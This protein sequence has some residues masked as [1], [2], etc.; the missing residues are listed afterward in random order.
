L[1]GALRRWGTHGTEAWIQQAVVLRV[2]RPELLDQLIESPRTRKYV[3]EMVSSTVALVAPRDWPEM[4]AALFEMGILPQVT[5]EPDRQLSA[6][7]GW[8]A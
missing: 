2:A 3:R 7:N 6:T 4:V 8:P 1:S 5:A